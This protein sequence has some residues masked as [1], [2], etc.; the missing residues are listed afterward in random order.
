VNFA[1]AGCM[2][3]AHNKGSNVFSIYRM[4]TN[5]NSKTKILTLT[6]AVHLSRLQG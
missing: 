3:D 1:L 5:S 6:F 2:A 4:Q